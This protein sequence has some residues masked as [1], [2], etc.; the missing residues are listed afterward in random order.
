MD[1]SYHW[2]EHLISFQMICS[3]YGS[4]FY[5]GSFC[6]DSPLALFNSSGRFIGLFYTSASCLLTI[7]GIVIRN[8][9]ISVYGCLIPFERA[10]NFLSN[11][12]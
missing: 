4:V 5:H 8:D 11:G 3:M 9:N 12:M 6:L 7:M 1:F 10:F 2:K